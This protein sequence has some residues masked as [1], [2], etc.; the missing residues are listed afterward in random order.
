MGV[1][2]YV[3]MCE[4]VFMFAMVFIQSDNTEELNRIWLCMDRYCFNFGAIN[5]IR[6]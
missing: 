5:K 4:I 1:Y 6:E 2:I 3:C